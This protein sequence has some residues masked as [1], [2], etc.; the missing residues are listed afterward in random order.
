MRVVA[1]LLRLLGARP[2]ETRFYGSRQALRR[3]CGLDGLDLHYAKPTRRTLAR[4]TVRL[5]RT[6]DTPRAKRSYTEFRT[7][8]EHRTQLIILRRGGRVLA[9]PFFHH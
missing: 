1:R 3:N 5:A 4:G 6:R 2:K 8:I 9:V 7:F